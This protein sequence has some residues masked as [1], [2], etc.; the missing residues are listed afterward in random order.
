MEV[1]IK[2]SLI[3]NCTF[4]VGIRMILKEFGVNLVVRYNEKLD[5]TNTVFLYGENDIKKMGSKINLLV[6]VC[7]K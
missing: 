3:R 6:F 1:Y 4:V 5:I 2:V 7:K